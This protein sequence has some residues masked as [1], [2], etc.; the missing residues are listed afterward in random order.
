MI[1]QLYL[2]IKFANIPALGW[3][4]SFLFN[5]KAKHF[6]LYFFHSQNRDRIQLL[7]LKASRTSRFFIYFTTII[8]LCATLDMFIETVLLRLL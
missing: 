6:F 5:N 4:L 8:C 3:L 2:I 7:Y 1:Q